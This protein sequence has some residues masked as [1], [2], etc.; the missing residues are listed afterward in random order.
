M[1][2]FMGIKQEFSVDIKEAAS[3]LEEISDSLSEAA[4]TLL[5]LDKDGA[6]EEV[7][8]ALASLIEVRNFLQQGI[9]DDGASGE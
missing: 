8:S 7:A 9:N 4:T 3:I 5:E 6:L 2:G 1:S